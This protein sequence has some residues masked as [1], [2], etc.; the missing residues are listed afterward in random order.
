[1]K[2]KIFISPIL[3][4]NI[5]LLENENKEC[6]IIDSGNPKMDEVIEYI[7]KENLDLK[8]I[9]L[10]H[11]HFDHI[12]GLE[13]ILNYKNVPVYMGEE[14]IKFLYDH[15]YSLSKWVNLEYKLSEKYTIIGLKGNEEIFNLKCLSTPGHTKGSFCYL[16]EK[17]NRIFTGDTM[18]KNT[19]GRTDFPTGNIDEMKETLSSLLKLNGDM[20]VYPGHGSK[21]NINNEKN[22][23]KRMF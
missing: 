11:G 5:Y 14:D 13:S 17:N 3:D 12:L 9:F 21:T 1:M 2:L 19:Y 7:E 8:M 18:F 20:E 23:Y 15:D 6:V 4:A 22:T 16:D 10:T